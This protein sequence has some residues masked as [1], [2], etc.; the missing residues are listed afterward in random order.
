[1]ELFTLENF[2]G[3]IIDRA[4]IEVS[5]SSPPR[6]LSFPMLRPL[7]LTCPCSFSIY[8]ASPWHQQTY[9]IYTGCLIHSSRKKCSEWLS[10][11]LIFIH[12]INTWKSFTRLFFV[13][14]VRV[15]WTDPVIQQRSCHWLDSA[16]VTYDML[17]EI[18]IGK[19]LGSRYWKI[20]RRGI[21]I[22]TTIHFPIRES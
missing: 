4:D 17:V 18:G 10:T 6:S 21:Y 15:P 11:D 3:E 14:W 9:V 7:S 1:M 12:S 2:W 8:L 19:E 13:N 5:I 20:R 16:I 22:Q